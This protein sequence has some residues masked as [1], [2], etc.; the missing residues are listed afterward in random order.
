MAP[1]AADTLCDALEAAD[2]SAF[3]KLCARP[4]ARTWFEELSQTLSKKQ[5]PRLCSAVLSRANA[6]VDA[7][8]E[9]PQEEDEDM[10]DAPVLPTA[11]SQA[12]SVLDGVVTLCGAVLTV[13]E[14]AAPSGADGGLLPT[15]GLLH[16]A[17]LLLPSVPLEMQVRRWGCEKDAARAGRRAAERCSLECRAAH[18]SAPRPGRCVAPV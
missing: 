9:S 17:L 6:A 14:A 1:P 18:P 13:K 7:L 12:L 15:L 2:P 11:Q 16:D 3:L 4:T 10:G 5:K 8:L